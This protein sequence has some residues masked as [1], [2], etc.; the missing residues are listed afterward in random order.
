MFLFKAE[1]IKHS[2]KCL[3]LLLYFCGF[4]VTS[5]KMLH[6]LFERLVKGK[7][8]CLQRRIAVTGVDQTKSSEVKHKD[9]GKASKKLQ[10]IASEGF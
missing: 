1:K 8:V 10:Q 6:P 3:F 7:E 4:K 5:S 2:L 9:H